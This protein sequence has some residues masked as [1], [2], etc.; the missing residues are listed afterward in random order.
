ME[1]LLIAL[2]VLILSVVLHE[3]AHGYAA[4]AQGDPTAAMLGRLTLNPIP[5]LDPIGSLLVPGMLILLNAPVLG[6][7]RP[8]PVNPRNFRNYKRGDIIV[9]LA[10]VAVNLALAI[11]CAV[12]LALLSWLI[13]L[14]P[15][16]A[17]TWQVVEVMLHYGIFINLILLVFNLLPIPPLDGSHVFYHLLPPRLGAQY[18]ALAPYGMLILFGLLFLTRFSFIAAPVYALRSLL[19]SLA[20]LLAAG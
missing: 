5:H 9:S 3:V 17:P 11:I 10:G 18:R 14:A 2:P 13:V 15:G 19:L 8:V 7:A 1:N 4:R 6:W 16:F 20:S 12:L